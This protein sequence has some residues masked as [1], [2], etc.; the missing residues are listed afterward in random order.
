[1]KI[2]ALE[3]LTL[4][5]AKELQFKLVNVITH[6]FTGT[7]F[8]SM[9]DVGVVPELGRPKTTSKVEEVI[10]EFFGTED[11]VLVRGAGT[12]SIRFS[13][14]ALLK[15][16]DK[17]LVHDAPVYSTTGTTFEA[18]GLNIVKADMNDIQKLLNALTPDIKL[19]YIQHSRQKISDS[20]DTYKIIKTLRKVSGIPIVTDE[21][22]TIFKTRYIGAQLGAN[23][24]C[25]SLFKLSGPEGIGCVVGDNKVIDMIRKMNS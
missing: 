4:N 3:S 7:E 6:H 19:V 1:M 15:P 22:Y 5:E 12:G 18:M 24:S 10:A 25:F 9:G 21:N 16:H 11:A 20:Y 23:A 2:Y 8:L 14:Q 17:I 13:L